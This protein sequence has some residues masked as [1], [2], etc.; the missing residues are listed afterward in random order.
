MMK[1]FWS[2]VQRNIKLFFKD[3][4]LF[5]VA[6]ISPVILLALFVTFLGNVYKDAFLD[7]FNNFGISIQ[8]GMV[9]G[10]VVAYLFASLEDTA[11]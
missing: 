11:S 7:V 1:V 3:R 2:L 8:D 10:V 5:F 9:D 4:A 6:M